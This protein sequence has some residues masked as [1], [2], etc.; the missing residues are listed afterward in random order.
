ML[1]D[2]YDRLRKAII[3]VRRDIGIVVEIIIIGRG[4]CILNRDYKSTIDLILASEN[5]TD[6]ITKTDYSSDHGAIKT[7]FDAL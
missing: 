6:S 1:S 7:I 4:R 5:L 2:V 3:K